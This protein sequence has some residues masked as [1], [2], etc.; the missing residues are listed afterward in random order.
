ML[1][2]GVFKHAIAAKME[3]IPA[4]MANL[5]PVPTPQD[6]VEMA[7]KST[8]SILSGSVSPF[9]KVSIGLILFVLL[10]NFFLVFKKKGNPNKLL[11]KQY[12]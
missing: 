3:N 8:T 9:M 10:I 2:R 11:K 4:E 1:E 7:A 6:A 5:L 12:S